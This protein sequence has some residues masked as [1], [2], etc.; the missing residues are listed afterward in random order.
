MRQI[1]VASPKRS[2]LKKKALQLFWRLIGF[3]PDTPYLRLKYFSLSGR[4]PNL[5]TPRL[6]TEKLQIA[7]LRDRNPIYPVMVDKF[8][9]KR[10]IAERAGPDR[11]I[12]T[13]WIGRDLKQADWNRIPL[14]AVVKPTHSSGYGMFLRTRDDVDELLRADPGPHWLAQRH[15]RINREW[16]YQDLVPQVIVER[17][18][19][20]NGEVPDDY[21][22][23]VFSGEVALI[24]LRL[25]RAGAVY[26]CTLTPQWRRLWVGSG[27]YPDYPGDI[28]RPPNLDEM[29]EV[30]RQVSGGVDFVRVDLYLEG[31]KIRVGE[32]TLYPGGG[33]PG[34]VCP[35][36]DQ[37]L[38][39]FWDAQL[40]RRGRDVG[41]AW[42]TALAAR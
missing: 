41:I 38:G 22:F 34:F 7:K 36:L 11:V 24:R 18:L 39:E 28:P 9:A 21:S 25:H 5:R 42:D 16:A 8:A 2:W 6:F 19:T 32:L 31:G 30:A 1:G 15:D 13:Y 40:R 35:A 20:E 3:L 27:C 12:E 17:M 26:E 29:L 10:L 33:F 4:F 14:P 23:C 37:F